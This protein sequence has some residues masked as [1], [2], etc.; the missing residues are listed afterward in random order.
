M[1]IT[2]AETLY[3]AA[4]A[5]HMDKRKADEQFGPGLFEKA[6]NHHVRRNLR[7]DTVKGEVRDAGGWKAQYKEWTDANAKQYDDAPHF[8]WF[9]FFRGFVMNSCSRM[10]RGLKP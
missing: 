10:S 1:K 7:A 6:I 4:H 8:V 5:I 9:D 3:H 2:L